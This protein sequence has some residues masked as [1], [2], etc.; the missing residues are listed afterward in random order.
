MQKKFRKTTY[1][2]KL[3]EKIPL[4]GIQTKSEVAL[5]WSETHVMEI[6]SIVS[7]QSYWQTNQPNNHQTDTSEY[8]T[9][10]AEVIRLL[11][12]FEA[13]I[14]WHL[15]FV[16]FRKSDEFENHTGWNVNLTSLFFAEQLPSGQTPC[17]TAPGCCEGS[18]LFVAICLHQSDMLSFI[19][20]PQHQVCV[21][22]YV[23]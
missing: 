2:G 1:L 15:F 21:Y 19:W 23:Y 18:I 13:K 11:K 16:N 12:M 9:S 5:F 20:R 17:L 22:T 10:L 6:C 7:V 8:I 4:V 14:L 3:S